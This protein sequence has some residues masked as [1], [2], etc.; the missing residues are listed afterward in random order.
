MH[1]DTA[2]NQKLQEI[3]S[4]LHVSPLRPP[5]QAL[6]DLRKVVA[7]VLTTTDYRR[8]YDFTNDVMPAASNG[9]ADIEFFVRFAPT[10]QTREGT[11]VK[12]G[13]FAI[14]VSDHGMKLGQFRAVPL[15]Q[16]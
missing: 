3:V 5:A 8:F 12:V 9:D 13:T 1:K 6:S 11:I 15:S 2:S 4:V 14:R 16:D 10:K 7:D